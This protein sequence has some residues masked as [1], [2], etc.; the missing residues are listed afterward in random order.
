MTDKVT[1]ATLL[2]TIDAQ[3]A[4]SDNILLL[5]I[6]SLYSSPYTVFELHY[7]LVRLSKSVSFKHSAQPCPPACDIGKYLRSNY[8]TASLHGSTAQ[9]F[10]KRYTE[11]R[12]VSS[13][14]VEYNH[15]YPSL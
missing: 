12:D 3:L 4:T 8:V 13:R 7:Q 11:K 6:F 14:G 5:L 1:A 10:L 9:V 15:T 2:D